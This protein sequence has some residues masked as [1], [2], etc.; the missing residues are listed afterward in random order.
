MKILHGINLFFSVVREKS[1]EIRRAGVW[2]MVRA[3]HLE[4]HPS[5]AACG[6]IEKLQVH[7]IIPV[8][9]DPSWELHCDNLITLCMDIKECHLNVGHLG[10][11]KRHNPNVEKEAKDLKEK[12]K[13][14]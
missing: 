1:K 4:L 10:S 8:H 7:H 12:Y 2:D 13:C 6:S 11:W 5:C 14:N 3:A 9:V